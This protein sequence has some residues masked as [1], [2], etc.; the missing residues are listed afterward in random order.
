MVGLLFL[1]IIAVVIAN[2]VIGAGA[3]VVG[4]ALGDNTP[5]PKT[6]YPQRCLDCHEEYGADNWADHTYCGA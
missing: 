3:F 1:I 6:V 2:A 4:A 5:R